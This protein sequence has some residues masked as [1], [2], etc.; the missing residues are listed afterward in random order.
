[1]NAMFVLPTFKFYARNKQSKLL[2]DMAKVIAGAAGK[3]M[4]TI[5]TFEFLSDLL[6]K[7]VP[8]KK[9]R[10]FG[11]TE[12]DFD[13][14]ADRVLETQ[15]RLLIQSYIVPITKENLIEIYSDMYKNH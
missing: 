1:V 8:M 9:M 12:A 13:S 10:D 5:E 2:D 14:Y 4:G 6:S 7:I 11:V 3:E 15:Q